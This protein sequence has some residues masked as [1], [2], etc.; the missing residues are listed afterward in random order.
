M[1]QV[2]RV[3]ILG[4][5]R[6][7]PGGTF[8]AP[9]TVNS[10]KNIVGTQHIVQTVARFCFCKRCYD[11][12][13]FFDLYGPSAASRHYICPK[14]IFRSLTKIKNKRISNDEIVEKTNP[15]IQKSRKSCVSTTQSRQKCVSSYTLKYYKV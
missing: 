6:G 1:V 9:C 13:V 10:A 8:Y 3:E 5:L 14:D 4:A 2:W 15:S 7:L 12:F 11:I